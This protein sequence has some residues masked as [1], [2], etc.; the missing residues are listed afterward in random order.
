MW[1]KEW[2]SN[3]SKMM[4]ETFTRLISTTKKRTIAITKKMTKKAERI[5]NG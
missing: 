2:L 5:M 3:A 4:T 1:G